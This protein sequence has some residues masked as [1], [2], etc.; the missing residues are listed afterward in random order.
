MYK[1]IRTEWKPR[2]KNP[3]QQNISTED[4]DIGIMKWSNLEFKVIWLYALWVKCKS[5]DF[6]KELKKI[7]RVSGT[8][9]TVTETKN[10]VNGLASD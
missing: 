8:K 3:G 7:N 2:E 6:D 9:K 5:E 1:K 10:S 4:W